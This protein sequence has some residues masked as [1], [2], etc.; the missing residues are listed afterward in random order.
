[1]GSD[2]KPTLEDFAKLR[3]FF[4]RGQDAGVSAILHGRY[5]VLDLGEGSPDEGD[6]FDSDIFA[7]AGMGESSTH[8]LASLGA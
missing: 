7:D 1:M 6:E 2:L 8:V 4:D 3:Q 5:K